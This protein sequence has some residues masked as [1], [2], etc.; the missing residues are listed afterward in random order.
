MTQTLTHNIDNSYSQYI[1]TTGDTF[2][3]EGSWTSDNTWT[4][5]RDNT[6]VPNTTPIDRPDWYDYQYPQPQE[7]EDI[8]YPWPA[9]PPQEPWRV[10]P[11]VDFQPL[12][13]TD[14]IEKIREKN[15]KKLIKIPFEF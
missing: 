9:T 12:D 10:E 5:P 2:F 1:T 6:A 4:W 3:T 15:S 7:T 11:P 13:L 8:T 14:L